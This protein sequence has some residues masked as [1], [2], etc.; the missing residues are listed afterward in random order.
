MKQ[1]PVKT[2][3]EGSDLKRKGTRKPRNQET[4]SNLKKLLN[5]IKNS[6]R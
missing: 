1:N 6:K 3:N 5:W 2:N 4:K